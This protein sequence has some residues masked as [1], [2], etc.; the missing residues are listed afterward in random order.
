MDAPIRQ[1]RNPLRFQQVPLI[2][3]RAENV[4]GRQYPLLIDNPVAGQNGWGLCHRKP[5]KPCRMWPSSQTG[6]L[7]IGGNFPWRNGSHQPVDLLEKACLRRL[8]RQSDPA[9]SS[10]CLSLR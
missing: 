9:A 2:I 4:L 1:K 3:L 7:S 5:N 6:Q 8:S 10:S